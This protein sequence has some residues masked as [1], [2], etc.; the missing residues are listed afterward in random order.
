MAYPYT[1]EAQDNIFAPLVKGLTSPTG[2]RNVP[3]AG[4]KRPQ[5]Q[6]VA[7]PAAPVAQPAYTPPAPEQFSVYG[8]QIDLSH[9][10]PAAASPIQTTAV[11]GVVRNGSSFSDTE[12][13]R[14]AG[15]APSQP[16]GLGLRPQPVDGQQLAIPQQRTEAPDYS[17][18]INNLIRQ[19]SAGGDPNS[20]DSQLA[21]KHSRE[22]ARA[23]LAAIGGLQQNA[24][25]AATSADRNAVDV[26]QA[27]QQAADQS[28]RA[29]AEQAQRDQ[30]YG[31]QVSQLGLS[32]AT[33]LA[34]AER[35][36]SEQALAE[37]KQ[38]DANTKE[39]Q[40]VSQEQAQRQGT[41]DLVAAQLGL[42]KGKKGYERPGVIYGTNPATPE[43]EAQINAALTGTSYRD[44]LGAPPAR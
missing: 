31:L 32:S 6:P 1:T 13:R 36:A 11:P 16:Q 3:V 39:A 14:A 30:A 18:Q 22:G 15:V 34:N 37:A 42:R 5:P 21:A 44:I 38:A 23:G 43:E 26:Y 40:R 19:A 33:A 41:S 10:A 20:F 29:Q 27:Q 2:F 7:A 17:E 12:E 25:Q 4:M 24:T 8:P 9:S 28:A 35:G